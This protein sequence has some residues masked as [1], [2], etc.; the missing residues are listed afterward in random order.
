VQYFVDHP[1]QYPAYM[2]VDWSFEEAYQ[3]YQETGT[4]LFPHGGGMQLEVIKQGIA[5]GEYKTTLGVHHTL[6]AFQMHAIRDLGVVHMITGF[7]E[8]HDLDVARISRAMADGKK[9]AFYATDFFRKHV[10]G[11]EGA[12]VIGTADDLGMRITRWIDGEFVFTEE[13]KTKPTRFADTIGR[14]VVQHDVVKSKAPGAWGAQTF[15][16]ETFDI[17]Y[18][19]L[20]PRQVE[21]LLMGAGRSISA[22]NPSLLRVMALTMVVGQGAGVAA[23][24]SA[25]EGCPPR[26]VSITSVQEELTR[27]GVDLG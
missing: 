21:G 2:D 19:C 1:D 18:R 7:V 11:F 27:Q 5:S 3:Q 24:I 16:D 22:S 4:F 12:C 9:V 6:D 14:G 26:D 17:P 13:M 20:L 10:P 23:A 8:I 15:T 25:R